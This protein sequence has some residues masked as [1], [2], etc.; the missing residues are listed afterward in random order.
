MVSLFGALNLIE[1][2]SSKKDAGDFCCVFCYPSLQGALGQVPLSGEKKSKKPEWL[3]PSGW[4]LSL[5]LYSR[6]LEEEGPWCGVL[7]LSPLLEWENG[8]LEKDFPGAGFLR[9]H[10]PLHFKTL[11]SKLRGGEVEVGGGRRSV[12]LWISSVSCRTV[13][14]I[15]YLLCATHCPHAVSGL[16]HLILWWI[17]RDEKLVPREVV[18]LGML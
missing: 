8:I 16:S 18:P 14:G 2:T 1:G 9:P 12:R 6:V 5:G 13:N 15:L 11:D 3:T 7:V 10:S 17:P 4:N